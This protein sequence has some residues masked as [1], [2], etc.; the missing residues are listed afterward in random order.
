MKISKFGG[1]TIKATGIVRRIDDLGR[2][3][4]P[5]EIRRTLKIN[6]GDQIEIAVN[7]DGLITLD[8]YSPLS[9]ITNICLSFMDAIKKGLNKPII[10]IDKEMIVTKS[11]DFKSINENDKISKELEEILE[12]RNDKEVE[13]LLITDK[14]IHNGFSYIKPIISYGDLL[15]AIIILS[16]EK[17]SNVEEGYI[18]LLKGFLENYL[19][20]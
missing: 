4:I 9:D 18:N 13:N 10:I 7:Q 19:I 5:K 20:Y 6:C 14:Y 11:S 1:N 17:L 16:S 15:G 12:I 3:V 8:K 2:I